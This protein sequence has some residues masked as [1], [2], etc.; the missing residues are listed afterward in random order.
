MMTWLCG[1]FSPAKRYHCVF[2][3]CNLL[4]IIQLKYLWATEV[5]LWLNMLEQGKWYSTHATPSFLSIPPSQTHISNYNHNEHKCKICYNM[6]H[7]YTTN[8]RHKILHHGACILVEDTYQ[9]GNYASEENKTTQTRVGEKMKHSKVIIWW[10]GEQQFIA[11]LKPSLR[12]YG[13]R[14]KAQSKEGGPR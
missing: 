12:K 7:M 14:S 1:T 3:C 13:L 5:I 10:C 11:H 6:I 9:Q 8:W 4:I 2:G